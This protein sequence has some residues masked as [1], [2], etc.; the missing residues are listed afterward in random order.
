MEDRAEDKV[1][2]EELES[3]HDRVLT[4]TAIKS[5]LWLLMAYGITYFFPEQTWVWYIVAI[6]IGIAVSFALFIKYAAYKA[7]ENESN[8]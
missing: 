2:S 1:V 7:A 3:F 5:I 4:K 8:T 6:F